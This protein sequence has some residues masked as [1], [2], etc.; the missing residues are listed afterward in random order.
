[1]NLDV[2]R[3]LAQ[4]CDALLFGVMKS[5]FEHER[6]GVGCFSRVQFG[7]RMVIG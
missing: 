6:A 2:D 5:A 7:N 4:S 1:M 3:M